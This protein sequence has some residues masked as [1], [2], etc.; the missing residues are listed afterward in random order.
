MMNR[1]KYL[2]RKVWNKLL[3]PVIGSRHIGPGASA[4]KIARR[5]PGRGRLM[6]TLARQTLARHRAFRP[7]ELNWLLGNSGSL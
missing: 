2:E 6:E 4:K 3:A 7:K 1:P 5:A